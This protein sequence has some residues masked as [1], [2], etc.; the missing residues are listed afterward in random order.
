[1]PSP[2]S[3]TKGDSKDPNKCWLRSGKKEPYYCKYYIAGKA[4]KYMDANGWCPYPHRTE[5]KV[6]EIRAKINP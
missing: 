4:C 6:K 1:M 3:V 2:R 5:K